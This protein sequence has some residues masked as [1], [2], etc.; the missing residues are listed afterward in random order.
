VIR[1]EALK[2]AM[3]AIGRKSPPGTGSDVFLT[4]FFLV[5]ILGAG[6]V[7]LLFGV[8][9]GKLAFCPCP[10]YLLTGI[11]CPGCGMTRACIALARGE[12]GQA[13]Q[14]N[15]FSLGLIIFAGA[16]ALFPD[17]SR[18]FWRSLTSRTRT[19]CTGSVLALILCFWIY[20]ILP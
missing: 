1:N 15:P 14:Y 8:S 6:L 9:P 17:R 16:F 18:R 4:R 12:I 3:G 10:F 20:R 5:A 7:S 2:I 13:L 19:L 11:H